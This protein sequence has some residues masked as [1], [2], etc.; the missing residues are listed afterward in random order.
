MI[1]EETQSSLASF[2]SSPAQK[3]NPFALACEEE[4]TILCSC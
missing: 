1:D 3:M 4:A 2:S